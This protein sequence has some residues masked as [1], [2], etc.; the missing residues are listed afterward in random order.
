MENLPN[1][2]KCGCEY[3][4]EDGSLMVCP[5]CANEWNPAEEAEKNVVKD[6][7]GN[8]LVTGD[9]VVTI[10]DLKVK[11]ASSPLKK[12]TKVKNIRL[13]DEPV[14]GHDI[15]CRID[16]FGAMNLKSSVVKKA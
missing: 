3:T 16:G 1:C 5:E 2:P 14:E 7:N 13:I 15:A 12:G 11:G 10:K 4:Y 8:V 9:S 6:S